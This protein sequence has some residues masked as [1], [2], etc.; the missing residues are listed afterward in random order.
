MVGRRG[1]GDTF[2]RI[3][4]HEKPLS[5]QWDRIKEALKTAD[6]MRTETSRKKREVD[7]ILDL[8]NQR[9]K[10]IQNTG[11]KSLQKAFE[12]N[13]GRQKV[14]RSK[15]KSRKIKSFVSSMIVK[16]HI[17]I[18]GNLRKRMAHQSA[19]LDVPAVILMDTN[20]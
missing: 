3:F 11:I 16:E 1:K 12:P 17:K 10:E 20:E 9:C 2:L 6:D 7:D 15:N 13:T 4:C 18:L 5:R 8:M 19:K 14:Q